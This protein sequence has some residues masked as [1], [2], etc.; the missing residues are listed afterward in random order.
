MCRNITY[1]FSFV[2]LIGVLAPL[3]LAQSYR[4]DFDGQADPGPGD[5]DE[6]GDVDG[7]DFLIWQQTD[8]LSTSDLTDWQTNYGVGVVDRTDWM[9]TTNW[10]DD[11]FEYALR[12][13]L[14]IKGSILTLNGFYGLENS[15]Q[16][17]FAD[18]GFVT[19]P[20]LSAIAGEPA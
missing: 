16:L 12:L 15:P 8:P 20:A 13:T 17:L 5:F 10:S 2:F 7:R 3:S 19:D 4:Y 14:M 18:P 9:T 11:G 6:D 1:F